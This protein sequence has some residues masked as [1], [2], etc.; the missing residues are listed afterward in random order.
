MRLI[1][2]SLLQ[3]LPGSVWKLRSPFINP[4]HTGSHHPPALFS[5]Q[6][7]YYSSSLLRY[8][9]LEITLKQFTPNVKNY[10]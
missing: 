9:L 6:I 3:H 2:Q 1:R 5:V 4:H 7:N 8:F 10:F